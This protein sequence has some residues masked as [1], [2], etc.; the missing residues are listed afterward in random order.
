MEWEQTE[1]A[2][3][4]VFGQQ[5]RWSWRHSLNAVAHCCTAM[6]CE[7]WSGSRPYKGSKRGVHTRALA[8]SLATC[9]PT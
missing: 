6:S 5:G 8:K 3:H 9:V 4:T 1:R 2:C 7:S